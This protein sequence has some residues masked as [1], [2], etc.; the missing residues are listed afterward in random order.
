M[1]KGAHL[2]KEVKI[3]IA[4]IHLDN[5]DWGATKIREKLLQ[6][7]KSMGIDRNFGPDWPSVS[8]VQTQLMEIRQ[9]SD[10]KSPELKELNNPW[11]L[12]ATSQRSIYPPI[13]PESIPVLFKVMKYR[14]ASGEKFTIREAKWASALSP[15][16]PDIQSLSEKATMYARAEANCDILNL[17]F[18]S[19]EVDKQVFLASAVGTSNK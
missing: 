11:S 4:D 18:D 10:N 14:D 9:N 13:T 15:L 7:L 17:P 12:G 8:A 6:K 2:T 1:A 5:T 19:T 3:L 16:I